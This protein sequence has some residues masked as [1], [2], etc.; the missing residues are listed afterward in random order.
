M[1]TGNLS[2]FAA[3]LEDLGEEVLESHILG[4]I[5]VSAMLK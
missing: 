1:K 4:G 3:D 2:A 5:L